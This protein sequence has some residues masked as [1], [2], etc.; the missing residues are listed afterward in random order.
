VGSLTAQLAARSEQLQEA[1]AEDQLNKM[2]IERLTASLGLVK[3]A[4][5]SQVEE[6]TNK[7]AD[8]LR[9]E[10]ALMFAQEELQSEQFEVAHLKK[11]M[12]E[13]EREMSTRNGKLTAAL[14]D[15]TAKQQ[16]AGT[17]ELERELATVREQLG[18]AVDLVQRLRDAADKS[19][20]QPPAPAAAPTCGPQDIPTQ[21]ASDT[22]RSELTAARKQRDAARKQAAAVA[23]QEGQVRRECRGLQEELQEAK[24]QALRLEASESEIAAEKATADSQLVAK[25]SAVEEIRAELVEE[26]IRVQGVQEELTAA[27]EAAQ[28]SARPRSSSR[29]PAL[30]PSP[31]HSAVELPVTP[32]APKPPATPDT[33]GKKRSARPKPAGTPAVVGLA[34]RLAAFQRRPL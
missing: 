21:Q 22:L 32:L 9:W 2:N 26:R 18:D 17:G 33:T 25:R 14:A 28:A 27:R 7:D 12:A 15:A 6:G 23:D 31:T 1:A 13:K 19:P 34:S 5:Q 3:S 20:R 10:K 11:V 8:M 16:D 4:L 29:L 30:T 24:L